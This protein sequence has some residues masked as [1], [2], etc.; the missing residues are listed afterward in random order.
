MEFIDAKSQTVITEKQLPRLVIL[1][2]LNGSGKTRGLKQMQAADPGGT[3]Y[4]DYRNFAAH[5]GAPTHANSSALGEIVLRDSIN[6]WKTSQQITRSF[7][8]PFAQAS[9]EP[10]EGS[11]NPHRWIENNRTK[12]KFAA[13][14]WTFFVTFPE[15]KESSFDTHAS[16]LTQY[17]EKAEIYW[18]HFEDDIISSAYKEASKR[19]RK[20]A[21]CITDDE[22]INSL[23]KLYRLTHP[24]QFDLASLVIEYAN[25][26]NKFFYEECINNPGRPPSLETFRQSNPDPFDHLNDILKRL[27]DDEAEVFQFKVQSNVPELPLTYE[28]LTQ[29]PPSIEIKLRDTNTEESRELTDLSSGEQTLLALATLLYTHKYIQP[30]RAVYLDEIDAS[31]HPTMIEAMIEILQE[32]SADTRIY[33]ATHSPSTVALAPEE[34]LFFVSNSQA[35]KISRT[36]AIEGLTQGFFTTEGITSV[37]RAIKGVDKNI[38]V[39][40]EGKNVDY[41]DPILK[42]LGYDD[43]VHVHQWA[44]PGSKGTDNL[45]PL[46]ALFAEMI[47]SSP[48]NRKFVFLFDCDA[49]QSKF[50]K[51]TEHVVGVFLPKIKT[52]DHPVRRGIENIITKDIFASLECDI[53]KMKEGECAIKD[54]KKDLVSKHFIAELEKGTIDLELMRRALK[55]LLAL[56]PSEC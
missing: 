14:A 5:W 50:P 33:L 38:I 51:S 25:K 45:K 28:Q 21:H 2:G 6:D 55:D 49:E 41:L 35:R 11:N 20:P 44:N 13:L 47:T 37:F 32:Q 18:S 40:S 36:K 4:I 12:S 1:T 43:R 48:R 17:P 29:L 26:R 8:L 46:M 27:A 56:C 52:E 10:F 9:Y 16:L 3:Q 15:A 54:D 42:K 39:I 22:A 34:S 31:L 7:G 30:M 53:Y 19:S 23:D 24:L